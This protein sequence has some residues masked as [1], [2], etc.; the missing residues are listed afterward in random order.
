MTQI[1]RNPDKPLYR[2]GNAVLLALVAYNIILIISAKL[3]Y[4]SR[5]A[6]RDK[7]WGTMSEGERADYLQTTTDKG[8][9]R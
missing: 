3:Y 6:Q 4:K 5:N 7:I 8:N 1:Y 9:K 2:T